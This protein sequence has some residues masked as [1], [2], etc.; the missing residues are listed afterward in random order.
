MTPNQAARFLHMSRAHLNKLIDANELPHEI[1]GHRDRRIRVSD[2]LA[3]EARQ[4][5]ARK[6]LAERFAHSDRDDAALIEEMLAEA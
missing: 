1:V 3:F 5:G 6:A 2:V 4:Q